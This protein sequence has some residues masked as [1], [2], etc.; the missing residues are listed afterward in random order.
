MNRM[1]M[2][3]KKKKMGD[4]K[5]AYNQINKPDIKVI[6]PATV[7]TLAQYKYTPVPR[8]RRSC[9]LRERERERERERDAKGSVRLDVESLPSGMARSS[10]P[11]LFDDLG[12]LSLFSG[13]DDDGEQRGHVLPADSSAGASSRTPPAPPPS[14]QSEV[15]G[16]RRRVRYTAFLLDDISRCSLLDWMRDLGAESPGDWTVS[17]DHVTIHHM[18]S[19]E[20][21]ANFPFGVPCDMRVLGVAGDE[22]GGAI[23]SRFPTFHSQPQR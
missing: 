23:T 22:R 5:V 1:K 16:R 19:A 6:V 8:A 3:I 15:A 11:T 10:E 20:Q 17:C 2:K 18:P 9:E 7:A 12:R 21:L 4:G 13:D 14:S